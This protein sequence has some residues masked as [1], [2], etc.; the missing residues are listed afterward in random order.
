MARHGSCVWVLFVMAGMVRR[1]K[2]RLV[3]S[4]QGTAGEARRGKAWQARLGTDR[5]VEFWLVDVWIGRAGKARY[6][7]DF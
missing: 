4:G 1:V 2:L 7:V 6:V 5:R 3:L